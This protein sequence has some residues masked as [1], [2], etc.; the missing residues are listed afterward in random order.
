M[1][2]RGPHGHVF[3]QQEHAVR[4]GR[5]R[6][7]SSPPFKDGWR[8]S[9]PIKTFCS[10]SS[11]LLSFYSTPRIS[12]VE[13]WV[14]PL[15]PLEIHSHGTTP[16]TLNIHTRERLGRRDLLTELGGV[17][18]T[19]LPVQVSKAQREPQ[20]TGRIVFADTDLWQ[21][22][23]S[24]R[25]ESPIHPTATPSLHSMADPINQSPGPSELKPPPPG[26]F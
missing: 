8:L 17:P 5:H 2:V 3:L 1:S 20:G 25:H 10:H 12:W 21:K 18:R 4:V 23:L 11:L 26:P 14:F 24:F 7:R 6:P 15:S 13:R 19:P 9:T 16:M 22:D